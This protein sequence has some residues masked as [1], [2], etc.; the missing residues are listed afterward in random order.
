MDF[1]TYCQDKETFFRHLLIITS[2][3]FLQALAKS[4]YN[5]IIYDAPNLVKSKY[6]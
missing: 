1:L 4:E 6:F 3:L 2:S 5:E